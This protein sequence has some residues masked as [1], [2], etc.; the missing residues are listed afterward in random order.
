MCEGSPTPKKKKKKNH[1]QHEDKIWLIR[2]EDFRVY[3]LKNWLLHL[4]EQKVNWSSNFDAIWAIIFSGCTESEQGL[5][6]STVP[7]YSL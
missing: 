7:K 2:F 4:N 6:I 5:T 1:F 3:C